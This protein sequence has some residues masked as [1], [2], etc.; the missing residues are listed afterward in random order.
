MGGEFYWVSHM[1][2]GEDKHEGSLSLSIRTY[3]KECRRRHRTRK[4]FI[5]R[6]QEPASAKVFPV[7]VIC[8]VVKDKLR[9]FESARELYRLCD[10]HWSANFSANFCG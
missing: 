3:K 7:V 4:V 2:Y 5:T 9:G 10:R 8:V 6:I 1:L